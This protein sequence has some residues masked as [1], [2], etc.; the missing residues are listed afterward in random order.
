LRRRLVAAVAVLLALG[1][2]V[3]A[4]V[5]HVRDAGRNVVGSPTVEFHPTPRTPKPVL[6]YA[7]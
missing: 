4:Y 2:G 6:Q 3:A 5:L 7:E 1:A